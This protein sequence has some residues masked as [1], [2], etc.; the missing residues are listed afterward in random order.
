VELAAKY[1]RRTYKDV[2]ILN[3]C[4][5]PSFQSHNMTETPGQ[6]NVSIISKAEAAE[7]RRGMR[8]TSHACHAL[9]AINLQIQ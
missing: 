8:T 5:Y 7:E 1:Q 3:R 6:S 2:P 4:M 9:S